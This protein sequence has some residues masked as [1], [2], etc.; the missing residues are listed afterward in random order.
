MSDASDPVR[1]AFDKFDADG[2]GRLERGEL[3]K[4]LEELGLD[5]R[6][7]ADFLAFAEALMEDY[8]ADGNGELDFEE[9]KKLYAQCLASEETRKAYAE[10]LREAVGG[11]V[12]G[13]LSAIVE[14][15]AAAKIQAVHRGKQ[16][17]EEVRKLKEANEKALEE[18]PAAASEATQAPRPPEQ[19][20]DEKQT[21]PKPADESEDDAV[22]SVVGELVEEVSAATEP[23]GDVDDDDLEE[24][25]AAA[26]KIQAVHRGKQA[27]KE[28]Q[29]KR[30][31]EAAAVKI[32]AVHRGKQARKELEEKRREA[33]EPEA[34]PAESEPREEPS[35]TDPVRS[36]FDKFDADGSGRLERGE[37]LKVLEELGLDVRGDA[38]FLAFAEALMEDYDA[39]GNG[40]L[41][42]E[43]FKKLYAQCLASEETRKA[44]AEELREAVGGLVGGALSAIV[45]NDA[46]AKIQAVHRGKQAR[47]EL[48]KLKTETSDTEPHPRAIEEQSTTDPVR[49]AFNKFDADGSG[50]LERG[51]LL[52][53]LEELGLDVSDGEFVSYAEALMEDYDAD[54]NGELD[55]EEFK[56]LYGQCLA[57]EETRKAYAEELRE[58][59]GGLVGGALSAI[60]ENDAAAKIQAVHRGKQARKELQKLKEGDTSEEVVATADTAPPEETEPAP[61]KPADESED[62]AVA[63]MV[64]EL[65]KEV[66][67]SIEPVGGADDDDLKEQAAAAL[68]IQAVHRGK[69]A[70]KELQ[71]KREMEAAAVK[72]Q[73]VHRGK[74]ARKEMQEK[75][76]MEAAAVK[77]QA[78]HRGK[79]ARKEMQE[80]HEMEAAALKIQAMHRG[81]QTRMELRKEREEQEAAALKIQAMHR[82]KQTRMELRK[83]REEQ[84]A[85]ALKIQA[86]HRGKQ[87]RMELR[88]EREEQEAA[89]LKIQAM[90]RGKQ[91]RMELRKE[92]EEQEAAA[93]K[94]QAMHRGKQT[95][96][97]LRKERERE[98]VLKPA[99]SSR[100]NKVAPLPLS[101]G[102]DEEDTYRHTDASNASPSSSYSE[103]ENGH[104]RA[105]DAA[106]RAASSLVGS[107]PELAGA[108]EA[109]AAVSNRPSAARSQTSRS[110]IGGL[111]KHMVNDLA[112]RLPS[113]CGG[114]RGG[115]ME[116]LKLI[117]AVVATRRRAPR[118]NK[119]APLA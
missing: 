23:V 31:M 30:E 22:E 24:Q 9:F 1:A 105:E 86:M 106:V 83:E 38:D 61:S 108:L 115:E 68:K 6:G 102:K 45:E 98:A 112:K 59:V 77:I 25:E 64:E 7:D 66:S 54:G 91:T 65:I 11:L 95:R 35:A 118:A 92:R 14:N 79:Q 26:L 43:E 34:P 70:R 109:A 119:V 53:V 85:A 111:S 44:Y 107:N 99:S 101:G 50:R 52:K 73:A 5:V 17:R 71:E 72:I 114:G 48:Q 76:E 51:E 75:H 94:I 47:K 20:V 110:H 56:K 18:T 87:T 3:L 116:A 16:A 60:V 28:L 58:A 89:A 78:V 74:Q 4:V 2:S 100:R 90:H 84:E 46:A 41:D 19:A 117:A 8:D 96:M 40:E 36:A 63:S 97:E 81:K 15:D 42:F 39:D 93:L 104:A 33:P 82:G 21:P 10:E 13:A 57:S 29:E 12:G 37:L 88:K 55:F 69:Q 62:D 80:K 27:R 67:A 103:D 113:L 49:A 32:Q